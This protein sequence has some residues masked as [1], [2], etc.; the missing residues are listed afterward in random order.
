MGRF[1][2]AFDACINVMFRF[3]GDANETKYVILFFLFF[4]FYLFIYLFIYFLTKVTSSEIGK[5]SPIPSGY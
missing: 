1:K 2:I 5:T 4:L 3:F